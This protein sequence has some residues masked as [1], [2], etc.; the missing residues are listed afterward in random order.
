MYSP[1]LTHYSISSIPVFSPF[2]FQPSSLL[3]LLIIS[4]FLTQIY[5]LLTQTI[6]IYFLLSNSLPTYS[7]PQQF[8]LILSLSPSTIA[9]YP[10]FSL[11]SPLQLHQSI[12]LNLLTIIIFSPPSLLNPSPSMQ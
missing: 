8:A 2:T 7:I 9:Y 6:S 4:P 5:F 1:L 12:S 11:P 10:S 3:L